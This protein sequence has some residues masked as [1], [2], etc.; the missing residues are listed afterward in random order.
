MLM[1]YPSIRGENLPDYANKDTCNLLH[2]YIDAHNQGS[3]YK[4][5]GDGLQA[6]TILKYQNEKMTFSEK[7]RHNRLFQKVL[8]KGGE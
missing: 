5:T 3:I 7:I 2:V 1:E 8:H 4:Y 6:I